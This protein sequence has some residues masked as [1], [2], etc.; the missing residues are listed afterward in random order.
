M[1]ATKTLA[2]RTPKA[3][4]TGA[5]A[6]KV[7]AAT[8]SAKSPAKATKRTKSVAVQEVEVSDE[9][10]DEAEDLGEEEG[11]ELDTD[12]RDGGEEEEHIASDSDGEEEEEDVVEG[13]DVGPD[14]DDTLPRAR[15]V[16]LLDEPDLSPAVR[17]LVQ[18]DVNELG[19]LIKDFKDKLVELRMR[20]ATTVESA[21]AG[22]IRTH[23]GVS[24]LE[25]KVHSMLSYLTNLAFYLLLKLHGR[26]VS[27][28]PVIDELVEL[29]IVMEKIKPLEQKLKYQID[30]L[31]KAASMQDDNK[32]AKDADGKSLAAA[33]TDPLN[34]KP[35]PSAMLS[36]GVEHDTAD[37][38]AD[39]TGGVYRPPKLAPMPYDDS[40]RTKTGRLTQQAKEKASRS[41]LLRDLRSQYDDRPEEQT[42]QG[43]GY[44]ASE[45]GA[46][47]EDEKWAERERFEEENF[48]RLNLTREDKKLQKAI[49]TQGARLRFNDEFQALEEDFASL[50]S[51]H[52]A[53]EESDTL[54]HG[55]GHLARKSQRAADLSTRGTQLSENGKKRKYGDAA[56][57]LAAASNVKRTRE[58]GGVGGEFGEEVRKR[59]RALGRIGKRGKG[60]KK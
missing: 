42:A 38:D 53:V 20:L 39:T 23:N 56:E 8:S 29:R 6:A 3:R 11:D 51:V 21:H 41:R 55:T 10:S 25:I 32:E 48:V 28:H 17:A 37:R 30:K 31:V 36:A 15:K 1:A 44:G 27:G 4:T 46:S 12:G 52:R 14:D 40:Q 60:G 2:K 22:D 54:T 7:T 33:V 35:N 19:T 50:R 34:F 5:A 58:A 24:L 16:E 26:P 43:T 45:V 59:K 47:K 13:D 9:E 57:L 49:E 18:K